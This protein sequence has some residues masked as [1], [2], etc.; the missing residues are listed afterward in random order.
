[1]CRPYPGNI[2]LNRERLSCPHHET[3]IRLLLLLKTVFLM[4]KKHIPIRSAFDHPAMI[5][6]A[7]P[8]EVLLPL[9][10]F[11]S[12]MGSLVGRSS[13]LFHFKESFLVAVGCG[14]PLLQ[15]LLAFCF[16]IS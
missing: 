14:N 13:D 7:E 12:K 1:M 16:N 11:I 3:T 6:T 8:N 4:E 15:K 2:I 9:A 5:Y 10:S